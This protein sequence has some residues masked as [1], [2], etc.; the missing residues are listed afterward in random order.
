M[1]DRGQTITSQP[2]LRG[3]GPSL[4]HSEIVAAVERHQL[5]PCGEPRSPQHLSR[6]FPFLVAAGSLALLFPAMAR[7]AFK[8]SHG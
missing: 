4:L 8:P 1:L 7:R 5:L 2:E 6:V 3:R